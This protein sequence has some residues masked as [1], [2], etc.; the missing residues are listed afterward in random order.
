MRNRTAKVTLLITI[1][2]ARNSGDSLLNCGILVQLLSAKLIRRSN[3]GQLSS[4]YA[5]R[6]ERSGVL[7]EYRRKLGSSPGTSRPH[8]GSICCALDG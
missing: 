7:G 3:V 1:V 2:F 8:T 5:S 4:W 6:C